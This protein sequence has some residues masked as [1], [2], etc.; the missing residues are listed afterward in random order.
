MNYYDK[1]MEKIDYYGIKYIFIES[2][3]DY[4]KL[5]KKIDTILLNNDKTQCVIDAK[6]TQ[7]GKR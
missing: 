1:Q 5:K 3:Y 2:V 7:S 4:N 6:F